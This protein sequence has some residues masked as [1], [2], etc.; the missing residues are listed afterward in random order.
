[1][2]LCQHK[3]SYYLH[4]NECHGG[5]SCSSHPIVIREY[6]T[7]VYQPY[8][9]LTYVPYPT[10]FLICLHDFHPY[11]CIYI[12]I[13]I[14]H[15]LLLYAN[16][17]TI[18]LHILC[19]PHTYTCTHFTPCTVPHSS[20]LC[21]SLSFVIMQNSEALETKTAKNDKHLYHLCDCM[22]HSY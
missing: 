5:K 3:G 17:P 1:M 18:H 22:I 2:Y 8:H 12:Y 4:S 6:P 20:P 19:L 16:T 9:C 13:Y 10:Y 11:I 14:L 21:T 7:L 15:T